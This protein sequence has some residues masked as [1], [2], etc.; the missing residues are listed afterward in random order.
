[1]LSSLKQDLRFTFRQF[2]NN[3]GFM[4][5]ALLTL[6]IGIGANTAIFS[7]VE[8]VLLAP[9]HYRD[10]QRLVMIWETNPRFPRVWNSYPNFEDW[11]R[12]SRSFEQMA[13]LREQGVDLTS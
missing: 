10:S 9:L 7:I 8:G 6:A 3:P 4:A 5:I 13:A 1:M 2:W 11:Q 12:S